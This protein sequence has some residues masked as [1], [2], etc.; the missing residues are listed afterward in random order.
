MRRS[1]QSV[2]IL[3]LLSASRVNSL[4]AQ[5]EGW[6][7]HLSVLADDSLLGRETGSRGERAAGDYIVSQFV[8]GGLQPG[9]NGDWFQQVRLLKR[10]IDESRSRVALVRRDGSTDTVEFGRDATVTVRLSRGG[11]LDAP[12]IFVGYGLVVP[13]AKWDDLAGLDL[14]GK[15]AV[16]IMGGPPT[17][18]GP[19]LAHHQAERWEPLRRAGAVGVVIIPQP[20]AM[21]I[22]WDRAVTTRVIPSMSLADVPLTKPDAL[23]TLNFNPAQ[24]DRLLAGSGHTIAELLAISESGKQ[25]PRF[26]LQ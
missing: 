13:E 3:I 8:R 26:E 7:R 9:V 23:I 1:L 5:G 24:A 22:P 25:H 12:M 10:S 15:V 14:R 6:W 18:P 16:V 19:L 20:R 17:I 11:R 21:D 2:L 4:Y